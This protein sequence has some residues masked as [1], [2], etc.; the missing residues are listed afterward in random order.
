MLLKN[1]YLVECSHLL[2]KTPYVSRVLKLA[3]NPLTFDNVFYV[4]L[5]RGLQKIAKK[6]NYMVA[7]F[8]NPLY[9][10]LDAHGQAG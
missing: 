9:P 4:Y 3:K 10:F 5:M 8:L 1:Y 7:F 6:M 2:S